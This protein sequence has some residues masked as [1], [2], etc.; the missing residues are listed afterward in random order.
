M[1]FFTDLS[2]NVGGYLSEVVGRYY[3]ARNA[4]FY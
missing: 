4:V 2:A 3:S 1:P